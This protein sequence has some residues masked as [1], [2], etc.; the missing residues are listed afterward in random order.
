VGTY[1]FGSEKEAFL[2][3]FSYRRLLCCRFFFA[4]GELVHLGL[5]PLGSITPQGAISKM[6]SRK[7]TTFRELICFYVVV[8]KKKEMHIH[9][10]N[11]E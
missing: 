5:S 9:S 7:V 3:A 8:V 6:K 10:K 4:L 11:I 2:F 1:R